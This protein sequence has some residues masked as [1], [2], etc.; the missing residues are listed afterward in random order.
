M[1]IIGLEGH[2][3]SDAEHEH[4]QHPGVA[5]VILFARNFASKAQV[6]ELCQQIRTVAAQPML[7]TVDQ[8]GGRVQRFREGF[9]AL[10]CLEDIGAALNQHELPNCLRLAR[11]HA[12]V[13]ATEVMASGLD[14]SFAPVADLGRGNLAIGNRAFHAEPKVVAQ[15]VAAYVAGMHAAGM[16]ATLKHFPGHGSV[17]EDTH[18]NQAIDARSLDA[19]EELDLIPFKAG[20]ASGADAVM[21]AH[22]VYPQVA[23]DPAGYSPHWIQHILKDRLGFN[24][25][26]FSDDIGMAAAESAGG[27]AARIAQHLNAGCDAVLACPPACVA[28]AVASMPVKSYV[29]SRF[30]S[31]RARQNWSWSALAESNQYRYALAALNLGETFHAA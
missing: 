5:G 25:V 2:A 13:M 15:F 31:L 30:D 6:I 29:L 27:V 7:I 26:V 23:P 20:I 14:L 18:F 4:L 24:G 16:A 28:D 21:M 3:L 10:P 22:V 8:E 19:I 9:A 11:E 12:F 17:L 1:L